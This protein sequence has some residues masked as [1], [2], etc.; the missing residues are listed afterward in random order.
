VTPRAKLLEIYPDRIIIENEGRREYKKIDVK[1]PERGRRDRKKPGGTRTPSDVNGIAPIASGPPPENFKEPGFERAGHNIV[2][3]DEYKRNLLGPQMTKVLQD[4][5][6]EPNIVGG[7]L[8]GFKLNRIREDSVYLKAG[9]QNG[10][11]VHE[12]NGVPL[13]DAAGAIRLLNSLRNEKEVE[14]RVERGGS[15]FNMNLNFQ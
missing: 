13:T 9:F 6:A 10:D 11:I 8:K 5:K 2:V 7:Q 12:I 14:I 3:S 15:Q 4:A 1:E